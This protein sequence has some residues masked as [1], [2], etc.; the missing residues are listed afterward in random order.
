MDIEGVPEDDDAHRM[1]V[2]QRIQRF[3][4]QNTFWF[5]QFTSAQ[6][7]NVALEVKLM[8]LE[9]G[10]Q[11]LQTNVKDLEEQMHAFHAYIKGLLFSAGDDVEDEE[12]R[13][14]RV[15]A[16]DTATLITPL[17]KKTDSSKATP[18]DAN[19]IV[20]ASESILAVSDTSI[21]SSSSSSSPSKDRSDSISESSDDEAPPPTL[22]EI[23]LPSLVTA[24]IERLQTEIANMKAQMDEVKQVHTLQLSAAE[25][26]LQQKTKRHDKMVEDLKIVLIELWKMAYEDESPFENVLK[27]ISV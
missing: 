1:S 24:E 22:E 15:A 11:S 4:A 16:T 6:Q 25:T 3:K 21:S 13:K 5:T 20:C 9:S 10:M 17:L 8:Q 7:Q 26:L 14:A 2:D 27:K 23:A 12:I 19:K 18:G